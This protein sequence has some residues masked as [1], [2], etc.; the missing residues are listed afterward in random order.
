M[1]QFL[2]QFLESRHPVF[3]NSLAGHTQLKPAFASHYLLQL[4]VNYI[5]RHLVFRNWSSNTPSF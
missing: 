2:F 4:E 1:G 3:K 5:D